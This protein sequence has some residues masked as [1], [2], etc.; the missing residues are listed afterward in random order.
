M[1]TKNTSIVTPKEAPNP[2]ANAT[3]QLRALFEE[4]GQAIY[5]F[6]DDHNKVCNKRFAQML[7]YASPE[8]WAAVHTSFPTAFVAPQSQGSLVETYQAAINDGVAAN[9][10]ITW[11]RKDGKTVDTDVILVPI[12]VEGA[13]LALHFV[14]A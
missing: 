12:D 3:Q 9:V 6:L 4:S 11:K 5:L 2:L 10:S 14:K 8:A 7:G 1:P 13:R